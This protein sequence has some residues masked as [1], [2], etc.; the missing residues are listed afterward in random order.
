M[1]AHCAVEE[2]VTAS[3]AMRTLARQA[4]ATRP[5]PKIDDCHLRHSKIAIPL[6]AISVSFLPQPRARRHAQRGAL[7]GNGQ[8]EFTF[9]RSY[10]RP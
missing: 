2:T 5:V 7:R 10:S 1:G 8:G 9:M 6:T 3:K 4:T